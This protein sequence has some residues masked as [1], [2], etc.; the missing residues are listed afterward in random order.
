[1]LPEHLSP[2]FSIHTSC[3]IYN[4]VENKGKGRKKALCAGTEGEE[5]VPYKDEA[6]YISHNDCMIY[7]LLIVPQS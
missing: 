7:P 4:E 1:M 3:M 5:R 2:S 6:K